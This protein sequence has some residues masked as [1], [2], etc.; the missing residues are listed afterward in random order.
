[1]L[2]CHNKICSF[3]KIPHDFVLIEWACEKVRRSADLSDS[4]LCSIVRNRLHGGVS[5]GYG[6]VA[7][8][9]A[10][11]ERKELACQLVEMESRAQDRIPL[12][13]LMGE[14]HKAFEEAQKSHDG[15]LMAFCALE[16]FLKCDKDDRIM[17]RWKNG[18]ISNETLVS[19]L[20]G[21]PEIGGILEEYVDRKEGE[22]VMEVLK[23]E[24]K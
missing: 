11:A 18:S 5:S 12:F 10:Q 16:V 6:Q 20:S 22:D 13:L 23:V 17:C 4:E 15:D 1:M 24:G 21:F 19:L 2:L 14:E 7:W 3:S 9:A 8:A